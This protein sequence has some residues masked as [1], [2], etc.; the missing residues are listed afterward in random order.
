[1]E[2]LP[3]IHLSA[4]RNA[5]QPKKGAG[6]FAEPDSGRELDCRPLMA[7]SHSRRIKALPKWINAQYIRIFFA[8]W[9]LCRD[10]RFVLRTSSRPHGLPTGN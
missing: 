6:H 8:Q 5:A 10:P 3:F 9:R 1:M 4:T 7:R 2:F